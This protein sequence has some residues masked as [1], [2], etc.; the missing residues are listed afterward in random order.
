MK[1]VE[2]NFASSTEY[3]LRSKD[4][5]KLKKA[6]DGLSDI[7]GVRCVIVNAHAEMNGLVNLKLSVVT[8]D[9]E[10]STNEADKV[11][12]EFVK[13][14][15]LINIDYSASCMTTNQLFNNP[16]DKNFFMRDISNGYTFV[17]RDIYFDCYA[18]G[19]LSSF[20]LKLTNIGDIEKCYTLKNTKR[21]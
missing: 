19:R 21:S 2:G 5:D 7:E 8:Y 15:G 1:C 9:D 12:E 6:I 18:Y 17:D 16:V 14:D 4:L 20:H 10:Y 3:A 13:S 11:L